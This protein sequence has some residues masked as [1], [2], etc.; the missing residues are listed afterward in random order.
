MPFYN[1]RSTSFTACAALQRYVVLSEAIY[2]Q[3]MTWNRTTWKPEPTPKSQLVP[4]YL[5]SLLVILISTNYSFV[6]LRELVSFTK[7]PD[8]SVKEAIIL[9]F[10]TSVIILSLGA[11]F[12]VANKEICF[13]FQ[14]LQSINKLTYDDG[15]KS[16]SIISF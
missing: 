6:I 1:L 3:Y 10:Y 11:I 9:G 7:D 2:P 16:I 12:T 13:I 8:I 14:N 5:L 4:W 15:K